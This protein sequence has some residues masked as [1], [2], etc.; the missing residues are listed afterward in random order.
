VG[1]LSPIAR[2]LNRKAQG[3]PI[4]AV[5]V[6]VLGI[7]IL[8]L[9]LIYILMVSGKGTDISKTFFNLGGNIS[10]NA[11]DVAKNYSGG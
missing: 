4:Y 9:V 7:V 8:A 2:F 5:I 1:I 10:S 11:T 6:I 3:L